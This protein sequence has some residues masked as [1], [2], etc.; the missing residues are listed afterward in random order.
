MCVCECVAGQHFVLLFT[1]A[2]CDEHR[3][4]RRA[5]NEYNMLHEIQITLSEHDLGAYQLSSLLSASSWSLPSVVCA[6]P[7]QHPGIVLTRFSSFSV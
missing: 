7:V 5:L 2:C 3:S 1:W 6:A 4:A